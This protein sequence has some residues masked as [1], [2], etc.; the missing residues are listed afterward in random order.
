MSDRSYVLSGKRSSV[1]PE[2]TALNDAFPA[3]EGKGW[4]A[5]MASNKKGISTQESQKLVAW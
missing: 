2:G 3:G 5:L 1:Q 4:L